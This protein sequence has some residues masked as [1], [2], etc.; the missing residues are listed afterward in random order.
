MNRKCV[1]LFAT[2]HVKGK[3]RFLNVLRLVVAKKGFLIYC[4]I[5]AERESDPIDLIL[6]KSF[7]AALCFTPPPICQTKMGSN[8][9]TVVLYISGFKPTEVDVCDCVAAS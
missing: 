8:S 3:W 6:F 1:L 2:G 5:S 4:H 9:S 7:M